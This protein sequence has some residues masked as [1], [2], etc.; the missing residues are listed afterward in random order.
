VTIWG[1]LFFIL[2]GGATVV[3]LGAGLLAMT[4]A[5]IEKIEVVAAKPLPVKLP[6]PPAEEPPPQRPDPVKASSLNDL[7]PES[8]SQAPDMG[9]V[10]FGSGGSGPA[11]A[12][13]GGFG[14]DTGALVRD[15]STVHRQ[16][17][18]VIKTSP[19][20]PTEA[21]ARGVS[22]FVVLKIFVGANGFVEEVKVEQSEPNGFFENAAI[23]AI[24]AWRFEPAIHKG[25]TVSAW[26][27]QRIKFELN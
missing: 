15:Q 10:G 17:R 14:G 5:Q 21:R 20:Y 12:G 24:R 26:T 23:S 7:A 4:P 8:T 18:A 6:T 16:P 25:T 13:A 3:A 22:G 1:W 2:M 27:T 11:I 19:E 9:G